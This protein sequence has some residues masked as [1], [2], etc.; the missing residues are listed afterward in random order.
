MKVAC[1]G[2]GIVALMVGLGPPTGW[3]QEPDGAGGLNVRDFGASGSAFETT[4][5]TTAGSNVIEV[6]D[7]GDLQVGQGV[8]V[9]RC[10][11][12]VEGRLYGPGSPYEA[13]EELGGRVEL[14]GYD[15]GAGSWLV[16][17][18]EV[19]TADPVT[20]RWSDDL[21]RTW[22]GRDVPAS[23]DWQ[24]LSKGVEV[25]F[26]EQEWRPGHMIVFIL[27]DQLLTTITAVEGN[28]LTLANPANRSAEDA[29]V[30][31]NDTAAL[32][33]AIDRAVADRR[34]L[35][36]PNGRYRLSGRLAVRNASAITIEGQSSTDTVLDLS[37][38]TGACLSLYAGQDVTVRNL[39]M[40]GHTG[41][42]EAPG[43]FRTSSNHG[44]WA[45]A[46][47]GCSAVTIHGTTR[48]LIENVHAYR[49]AS[50]A[51]YA[52]AATRT[53]DNEPE[54]Y[55]QALTYYR[56]SVTDCAAN[57]FNN[58]DTGENTSVLY[59][60]VDGAGWHAAEMPAKFFRFI[61]N[62]VRNSGPVTVGDMSH[63]Y[64]DLHRLGCGQ[65][66]IA[67]NVFEGIGRSRG[68][69]INHGSGQIVVDSNLF[70]NY[71][72]PA[73]TA[74]SY[75]TEASFPSNS[76][77]ITNNIIDMTYLGDDPAPRTGITVSASNTIASDNQIFVR[78]D[79]DERVTGI[80]ISEPALN[81]SVHDNQVS[82]CGVGISTGRLRGSVREVVDERTFLAS[83]VPM[84]WATSHR[85]RGWR[86]VWLNGSEVTGQSVVDH[87]D[88]ES[89]RFV[90]S[91]PRELTAGESFELF[92][93]SGANWRIS[94]NTVSGCLTP[95]R[96]DSYGSETSVFEGNTI[97][98]GPVSGV[99]AAV[100]VH[101][102]FQLIGNR[103]SGFDEE[104]SVALALYAD[105]AGR[106]T[107]LVCARN[108][109]A[110]CPTP[111]AASEPGMWTE[112]MAAG[113]VFIDER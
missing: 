2:A 28:R 9:S 22:A 77:T 11:I 48:T 72:G 104:G 39:R 89:T 69:A 101:G 40:V 61:G 81:V 88:A 52:Q 64:E 62:Y 87:F 7:R 25:R 3:A 84:E 76:V 86:I 96:L 107:P 111:V 13:R 56:C 79:C 90:L 44:F 106:Q 12:Q 73:I 10:N 36:L 19:Q 57:A 35:Y 68:I 74:S 27:R 5:K 54:Q 58:N 47:K 59:C 94:D 33:A 31:H 15:G 53:A 26:T 29:V 24:A 112:E 103:F 51:F 16:Y 34:N 1:V 108:I 92:P 8:M 50:E 46:L 85:Y 82:N 80:S 91:E 75:T 38:G 21:A 97:T 102:W 4:A 37:N 18:L 99:S 20:F 14:R 32:Q 49:M 100:Q 109:F 95:V 66:I 45:S 55:Q 110:G 105:R 98:R 42:A 71:N 113:N 65:A 70:I 6:A 41:L 23:Y 60:R 93:R 83:R 78:G 67:D 43:S 17:I 63:R 30:V